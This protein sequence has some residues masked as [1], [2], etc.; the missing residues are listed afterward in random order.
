MSTMN[1]GIHVI[2]ALRPQ[3]DLK[4]QATQICQIRDKKQRN[5]DEM[6]GDGKR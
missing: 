2:S 1:A 5:D 6:V 4:T 3:A